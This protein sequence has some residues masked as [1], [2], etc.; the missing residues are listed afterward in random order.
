MGKLEDLARLKFTDPPLSEAEERVVRAASDGTEA[1]CIDLGG[2]SDPEKADTW[3]ASRNVRADLIRWLC[4]DREAREQVDPRGI[5]ILGAR[6]TGALDLSF[7]NVPF[8]FALFRCRLE[9][10]LDLKWAKMPLLN[11]NGSWTG[12]IG[13]DGLKLEGSLFLR[14]GFHAEG[15]VR[16]PS[17]TIG[18]NLDAEGGRFKNSNGYA[19]NADGIKVTGTVFL[20]NGFSAEGT[21]RLL[22]ATIGGDLTARGGT[23]KN[24]IGNALSA[25]GIN[26]HGNVFLRDKFV[27]EGEVRLP[28]AEITG[29]LEVDDAWLDALNLDSA[30]ITGTF[31]W[32]NIHKDSN[33]DFPNKEWKPS[34]DLTNAIVGALADE[35]ASWPEKGRL[36]L[37]GFVYDRI[38]DGPTDAKTRLEWL[39][40]QPDELGFRPQPYEQLIA[41][42]QR[43][44]HEHQVAEV[45]IA[46]QKDLYKHGDLGW[47]GKFRSW[48]LYLA[49][50]YRYEPWRAFLGMAIL[51]LLGTL[52]FSVARWPS[53]RVMVPSDQ[54]AYESDQTVKT[55][56]PYYYPRFHASVYSLD[57]I[58]PF[59]LGQK[60]HWRLSE[61]WHC[62]SLYWI[63]E[64]YSLIQL[65]AG[66]MLLLV[67]AAV[68]AGFIKTD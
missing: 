38:T 63:F 10:D 20:R 43:M 44:G 48:I 56:L 36:I 2:G 19:L 35:E 18:G 50:G 12:A 27:A 3:P 13:A 41:V 58:S 29:R 66:W 61:K 6:I 1:K 33:P 39:R 49:V 15:G 14:N 40:R 16:L 67:A 52:V 53:V 30:Q 25:D 17:A 42:L 68:P 22:G 24:S 26:V 62:D 32:R 11:L 45:A 23:F 5:Q 37:D 65:F 47:W 59:D 55:P 46:K 8:S 7:T 64:V 4:V 60:S 9:Q 31:F 34:L 21:V 57:V 28:G 51:V 54:E